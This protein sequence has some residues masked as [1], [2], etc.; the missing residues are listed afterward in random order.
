MEGKLKQTVASIVEENLKDV[1]ANCGCE[2]YEVEYA[3]KQNGMN[4]TLFIV[5]GS[6]IVNIDDCEAVHR[7]VDP[8]LDEINPTG[9]TPY[10]LNVSSLGLDR[11]IK[12]D[13]D[14]EWNI[15]KD[16]DV[17]LFEKMQDKKEFEGMILSFDGKVVTFDV[18]G[19]K[20]EVPKTM[21]AGCKLHLD[22]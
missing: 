6:G 3:K 7:A 19:E 10:I 11:P 1:V 14:F 9:D 21:I 18:T 17:K 2:L 22:F 15:G 13:K 8:I 12:S 16:V 20:M 5:K 4:L